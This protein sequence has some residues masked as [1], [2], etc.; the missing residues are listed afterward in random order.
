MR[1]APIAIAAADERQAL[2]AARA[3]ASLTHFGTAAARASAALVA[4]LRNPGG[5]L[6]AATRQLEGDGRL[7]RPVGL[8][9]ARDEKTL[10]RLARE[11]KGTAWATLTV[12]LWAAEVIGD[13]AAGVAWAISLG[14]DTD[15][16]VAGGLLAARHG[17]EAIPGRWL[18]QLR[19]RERIDRLAASI[20]P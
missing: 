11:E 14:G 3:D 7:S 18:A 6:A 15:A 5:M 9:A 10:R 13:Y 16:A 8:V 20:A 12:G 4:A 2:R 17:A 1:C 19:E